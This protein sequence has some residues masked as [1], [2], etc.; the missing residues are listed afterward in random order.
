MVPIRAAL[1]TAA[2]VLASLPATRAAAEPVPL[3]PAEQV[4][5]ERTFGALQRGTR[6]FQA[7]L[8]QAVLIRP[9]FHTIVSVGTIGYQAPDRLAVRFSRPAGQALRIDG[10][11]VT[12]VRPD[13]PPR[14]IPLE[15]ASGQNAAALLDF[16]RTDGTRW[17]RDFSVSMSR[18]GDLLSVTMVPLPDSPKADQVERI[19]TVL[20]LPDHEVA[21]MRIWVNPFVR[22]DYQFSRNRRNAA[23]DPSFLAP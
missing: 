7:D 15:S 13:R 23:L 2:L 19:V 17:H 6:T 9:F 22:V 11:S 3:S 1:L 4:R 8:R 20:R 12:L 16:F 18:D 10:G 5:E 21:A 14:R